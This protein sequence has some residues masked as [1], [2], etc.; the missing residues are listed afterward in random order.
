MCWRRGGVGGG[1][2]GSGA[3]RRGAG[4]AGS[5]TTRAAFAGATFSRVGAVGAVG[6]GAGAGAGAVG[7]AAVASGGSA[8][9][10]GSTASIPSKS[11]P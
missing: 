6:A 11:A 10:G 4:I 1:L 5:H 8:T 7:A 2:A 9:A 3:M